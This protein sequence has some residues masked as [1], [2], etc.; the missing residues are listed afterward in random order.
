MDS[1]NWD[2]P[3]QLHERDDAGSDMFVEFRTLKTGALADLI[4]HVQTLPS[5]QKARL[6][7]D[8]TGVGS[9]NI[10]D[11]TALAARPDFPAS[12]TDA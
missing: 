6:V 8:A 4:A 2:A 12:Q 7:I 9:L 5:E 3:A 1:V 10:H 11:I